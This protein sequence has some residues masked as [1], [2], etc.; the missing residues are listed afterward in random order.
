MAS[1]DVASMSDIWQRV[2][3]VVLPLPAALGLAQRRVHHLGLHVDQHRARRRRR[4]GAVAVRGVPPAPPLI[5]RPEERLC[6]ASDVDGYGLG[7][8]STRGSSERERLKYK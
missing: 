4:G 5:A 6:G 1:Y 2:P 7:P 8:V 3:R